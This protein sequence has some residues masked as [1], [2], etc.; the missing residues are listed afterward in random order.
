MAYLKKHAIVHQYSMCE[1]E[2]RLSLLEY[3]KLIAG[4][5][6]AQVP[7]PFKTMLPDAEQRH[8]HQ[9]RELYYQQRE[10]LSAFQFVQHQR[11]E[12]SNKRCVSWKNL[13][14]TK[15]SV[16]IHCFHSILW[17][18]IYTRRIIW[19]RINDNKFFGPCRDYRRW[20]GHKPWI[21]CSR[22][23]T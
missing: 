8:L 10:C 20:T 19:H 22:W 11:L 4:R 5:S 2:K 18:V 9:I 14:I 15:Q 21:H 6:G 1:M 7:V 16:F 17:I 13:V 3:N 12:K 23:K